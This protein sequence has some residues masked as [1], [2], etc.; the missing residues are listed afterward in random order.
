MQ[1][2]YIFY[3]S[4]N[5]KYNQSYKSPLNDLHLLIWERR[6]RCFEFYNFILKRINTNLISRQNECKS[7]KNVNITTVLR[8]FT[9]CYILNNGTR[10]GSHS[11]GLNNK[12]S[13]I[14]PKYS[15]KINFFSVPGCL[16]Y[17]FYE[18]FDD[19]QSFHLM[20]CYFSQCHKLIAFILSTEELVLLSCGVG[21]DS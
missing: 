15:L 4:L 13:R 6:K 14:M 18:K 3:I 1:I 17:F 2:D 19:N 10:N 12:R 7:L 16:Q 11:V 21:E 5:H 20:L 8:I 9:I